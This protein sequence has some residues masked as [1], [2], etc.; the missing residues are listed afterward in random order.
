MTF[1]VTNTIDGWAALAAWDDKPGTIDLIGQV[2]TQ[3]GERA[4]PE[5]NGTEN[6]TLT[7][8][9]ANEY[10]TGF[11]DHPPVLKMGYSTGGRALYGLFAQVHQVCRP[12][13]LGD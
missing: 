7:L 11:L 8:K 5:K 12:G 13:N 9:A 4:G 1:E 6:L 3:L 2:K 10:W